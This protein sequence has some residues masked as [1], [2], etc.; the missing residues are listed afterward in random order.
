MRIAVGGP[1][2]AGTITVPRAA[3]STE[4]WNL[5]F[6]RLHF[7]VAADPT[8]MRRADGVAAAESTNAAMRIRARIPAINFHAA[9]LIWGE[10]QFGDVHGDARQTG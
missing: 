3:D 5:Q 10:R 4:P 6:D 1:N 9:E 8:R 2:V 7:D